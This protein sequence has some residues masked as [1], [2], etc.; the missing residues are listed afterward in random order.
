MVSRRLED[1]LRPQHVAHQ[2]GRLGCRRGGR[3][4]QAVAAT[5]QPEDFPDWQP[6]ICTVAKVVDGD[7]FVCKD[8]TRVDMLAIDAPDI[9]ACGGDW[10][11]AA[12]QNIFLPVGKKVALAFDEI[13]SAPGVVLAAPI[14]LGDDGADY[15]ISI[16]MAYVGLAK[17]AQVGGPYNT[18]Y[19]DWANASQKWAQT[20]GWNMWAPGKPFNGG[21]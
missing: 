3:N 15:N 21:C 7:T 20:A 10:A 11:A 5:S 18:K 8:G 2:P 16:V 1:R 14:V 19:T 13:T 9:N 4:G 17:A 12:L 6:P